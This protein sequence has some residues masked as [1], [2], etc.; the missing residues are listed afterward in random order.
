VEWRCPGWLH[1]GELGLRSKAMAGCGRGA[2]VEEE[3]AGLCSG[4]GQAAG[5][6]LAGAAMEVVAMVAAQR[7]WPRWS[8][9][10]P[11]R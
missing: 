11:R 10:R 7:R 9:R 8:E 1:G 5:E 4:R 6:G 2:G 3:A